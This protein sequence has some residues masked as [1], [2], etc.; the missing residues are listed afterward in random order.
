MKKTLKIIG[1][2]FTAIVMIWLLYAF[3]GRRYIASIGRNNGP[4]GVA[5]EVEYAGVRPEYGV[6]LAKINTLN[7][8]PVLMDTIGDNRVVIQ[9]KEISEA[10]HQHLVAALSDLGKM[11]E[12]RFYSINPSNNCPLLIDMSKVS[13]EI[14]EGDGNGP[15]VFTQ[16]YITKGSVETDEFGKNMLQFELSGEGKKAFADLTEKTSS[17]H[18]Q[19]ALFINSEPISFPVVMDKIITDEIQVSVGFMAKVRALIGEQNLKLAC[20]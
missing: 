3:Y 7:L 18:T 1:I 8:G 20:E 6:I 10:E 17:A 14:K 12:T 2:V 15:T 9:T 13:F 16:E 19:I 4:G 5:L 11:R